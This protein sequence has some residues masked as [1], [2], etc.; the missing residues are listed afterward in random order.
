MGESDA[1]RPHPESVDPAY[2]DALHKQIDAL[3]GVVAM[4]LTGEADP[5]IYMMELEEH[6]EEFHDRLANESLVLPDR[7]DPQQKY[8]DILNH[9]RQKFREGAG[10]TDGV[11]LGYKEIMAA[12]GCSKKYSYDL[13][14]QMDEQYEHCKHRTQPHELVISVDQYTKPE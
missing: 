4:L 9:A 13:M 12:S 7:G 5:E 14:R 8:Q 2:V 3:R 6:A 10:G 1:G 11:A